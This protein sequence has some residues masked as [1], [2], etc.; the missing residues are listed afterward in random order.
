MNKKKAVWVLFVKDLK[1]KIFIILINFKELKINWLI[2]KRIEII[3]KR[4]AK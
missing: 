4:T 3:L 1:R 2:K